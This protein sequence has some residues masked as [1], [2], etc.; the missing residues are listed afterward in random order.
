MLHSTGELNAFCSVAA[1]SLR[2]PLPLNGPRWLPASFLFLQW[3]GIRKGS[4]F[5]GA[6]SSLTH[7]PL[8]TWPQLLFKETKDFSK[9]FHGRKRWQSLPQIPNRSAFLK[10]DVLMNEPFPTIL[11]RKYYSPDIHSRQRNNCPSQPLWTVNLIITFVFPTG[12]WLP[13]VLYRCDMHGWRNEWRNKWKNELAS[14]CFWV[15]CPMGDLFCSIL[16]NTS[17]NTISGYNFLYH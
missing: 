11:N 8:E 13:S 6:G 4:V 5:P 3:E 12:W 2:S 15:S 16:S 14:F 7:A 17:V 10:I 9:Y 1:P